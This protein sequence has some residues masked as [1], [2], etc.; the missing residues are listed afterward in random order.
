MASFFYEKM[1]NL[2]LIVSDA[3]KIDEAYDGAGGLVILEFLHYLLGGAESRNKLERK[4][5]MSSCGI[6]RREE[7]EGR[8]AYSVEY[9]IARE[10]KPE[11]RVPEEGYVPQ[12]D[13]QKKLTPEALKIKRELEAQGQ[14]GMVLMCDKADQNIIDLAFRSA[15]YSVRITEAR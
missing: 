1:V 9:N 2:D 6:V 12:E 3:R 14:K 4:A 7:L 15:G 5:C 13:L 10:D 11:L 8:Y